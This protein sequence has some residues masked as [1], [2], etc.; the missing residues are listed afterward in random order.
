M[1]FGWQFVCLV[2]AQ[3]TLLWKSQAIKPRIIVSNGKTD[4]VVSID[5]VAALAGA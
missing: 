4:R 3:H 2:S 1:Y 5:I